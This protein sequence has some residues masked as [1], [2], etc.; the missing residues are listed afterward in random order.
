VFDSIGRRKKGVL[1]LKA[2]LRWLR[3][4]YWAWREDGIRQATGRVSLA[5]IHRAV[6]RHDRELTALMQAPKHGKVVRIDTR[7]HAEGGKQEATAERR[8]N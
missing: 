5:G 4:A 6:A 3:A 7:K 8:A 1:R 2:R